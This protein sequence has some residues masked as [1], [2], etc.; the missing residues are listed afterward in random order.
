[1][2]LQRITMSRLDSDGI[3]RLE[4]TDGRVIAVYEID[5]KYYATDDLCS[6]GQASLADGELDGFEILCPFHLGSFDIRTGRAIRAP[7]SVN[8][9]AYQ[10]ISDGDDIIIEG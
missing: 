3:T 7:C 4:L 5:G 8:I 10:V 6:H 9:V 2:M 1:M